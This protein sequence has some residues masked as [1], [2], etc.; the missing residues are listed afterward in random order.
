M[1]VLHSVYEI[2]HM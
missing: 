2:V 1:D